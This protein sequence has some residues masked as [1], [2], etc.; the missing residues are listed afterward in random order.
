MRIQSRRSGR[1]VEES[2]DSLGI[3]S[4]WLDIR[5]I[6][7]GVPLSTQER[8]P[9]GLSVSLASCGSLLLIRDPTHPAERKSLPF[10]SASSFCIGGEWSATS[11]LAF[12]LSVQATSPSGA[13]VSLLRSVDGSLPHGRQTASIAKCSAT[14]QA[15]PNTTD[16][17]V[18]KPKMP[19]E[20]GGRK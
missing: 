12:T 4:R 20:V 19:K 17:E 18:G 8:V 7:V 14:K 1:M 13:V 6:T 5:V 11:F 3:D 15:L 10:F 9:P 16:G 2:M